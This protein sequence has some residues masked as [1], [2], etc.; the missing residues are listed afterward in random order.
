MGLFVLG[1]IDDG[2][3]ELMRFVDVVDAIQRWLHQH[4]LELDWN[5]EKILE[6]HSRGPRLK[7][8]PVGR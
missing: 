5:A 2:G 4:E 8:S 6:I 1:R 7:A 3:D